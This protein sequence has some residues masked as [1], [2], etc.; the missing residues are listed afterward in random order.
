MIDGRIEDRLR[1]L[2][3]NGTYQGY[4]CLIHAVLL[5]EKIP[6]RLTLLS[7]WLYPD[8][9][10]RCGLSPSQVDSALRAAIRRCCICCPEEVAALC[11][12]E[13]EPSVAQFIEGLTASLQKD[14]GNL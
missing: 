8:V 6:Q 13:K 9:A 10:A 12:G 7:K 4:D 3:L 11:A 5:A 14:A 2:G 1:A